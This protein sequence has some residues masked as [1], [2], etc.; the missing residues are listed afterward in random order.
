MH[1]S[2][3]AEQSK[4]VR[5]LDRRQFIT[6]ISFL[7]FSMILFHG[8]FEADGLQYFNWERYFVSFDFS[9]LS[10]YP[11]SPRGLPLVTWQ[12]GV[13][14]LF[15]MPSMLF[16]IPTPMWTAGVLLGLANLLLF[17]IVVRNYLKRWDLLVL[18][19]AS[20]LLFTPA[21]Y[22][23]NAYSSEPWIIFLTL[24]GLCCIE[25]S[26][27]HPHS[28]YY[29]AFLLGVTCYFLL[30]V[31]SQNIVICFA[32]LAILLLGFSAKDK[33][34]GCTWR[35]LTTFLV[36]AAPPIIAVGFLATFNHVTGGSIFASPYFF[37]DDEYSSFSLG[38][39]KIIEVLFSSWHGL[40]F[41]HPLFAVAIYWLIRSAKSDW[42]NIIVLIAVAFQTIIQSSWYVWWMGL[43][44]YGA[45][46][47]CGV[48]VLV[49]Y[50]VVRCH[51]ERLLRILDSSRDLII[52]A[53][54]ATFEAYLIGQGSSNYIDYESFMLA[55]GTRYPM[56]SLAAFFAY[57][58]AIFWMGRRLAVNLSRTLFIYIVGL[59]P[60]ASLLPLLLH[61]RAQSTIHD[62][63]MVA[64]MVPV[65]AVIILAFQ[66]PPLR[67][68]ADR[69]S[70]ISARH[71]AQILLA[72]TAFVFLLSIFAQTM[73]LTSFSAL[74]IPNF[75]G[76]RLFDCREAVA[77]L[78]EYNMVRGYERDKASL[79][80]FLTRN[81]CLP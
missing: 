50:A 27:R 70:G 41:Y 21:G 74:A 68:L 25:W 39:M 44:T 16:R 26:R 23:L 38:H 11:K 62:A 57:G 51:K 72:S 60:A 40:F 32:L 24:C 12:Y 9:A 31:R 14:L 56:L 8:K 33:L 28:W 79:F 4:L 75:S 67:F 42:T 49:M 45:R 29:C 19:T 5:C 47:F 73:M 76:G 66:M 6:I 2:S 37:K 15:G 1:F 63:K 35:L 22:Y 48:S 10:D 30:L 17:F 59:Y 7:V 20:F 77:S 34:N 71:S 54:F 65:V 13:G 46:G 80:A 52:L 58:L 36:L 3:S 61:P 81:G 78:D 18:A 53:A 55:A 64:V 69:I 43:G